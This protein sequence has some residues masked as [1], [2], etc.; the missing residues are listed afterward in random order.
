MRCALRSA[1]ASLRAMEEIIFTPIYD[2]LIT[3][4]LSLHLIAISSFLRSMTV[5]IVT[6]TPGTG[7]TR[8]ARFL[9]KLGYH[10]L[11]VHSLIRT[12][13]SGYD[14]K[15]RCYTVDKKKFVR[16]IVDAIKKYPDVIIDSHMSHYLPAKHVDAC[17]VTQ[18]SIKTLQKRL[19]K[20]N[21]SQQK[22]RE[23][24]DAE[25]FENCLVEARE[26]GHR[27]IV[28]DTTRGFDRLK[29][30]ARIKRLL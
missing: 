8:V 5:I 19:Q 4:I 7:K 20:R 9:S 1:F 10:Y 13:H 16:M 21:Y 18:C 3:Y 14:R 6:G 29:L 30:I 11:D 2:L 17:V 12:I 27:V 24:L 23:N 25:I 15:K 26:Y 28:L 22:I